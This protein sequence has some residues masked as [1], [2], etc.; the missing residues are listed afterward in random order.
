MSSTTLKLVEGGT[1]LKLGE[2]TVE[3]ARQADRARDERIAA[4]TIVDDFGTEAATALATVQTVG[5]EK[6][7]AAEVFAQEA[8]T[9]AGAFY[10]LSDAANAILRG[11]AIQTL[12]VAPGRAHPDT[13]EQTIVNPRFVGTDPDTPVVPISIS[14]TGKNLVDLSPS[15]W[16]IGQYAPTGDPTGSGSSLRTKTSIPITPGTEYVRSGLTK[17]EITIKDANDVVTRVIGQTDGIPDSFVAGPN[18][19]AVDLELFG[20]IDAR[21]AY[22]ADRKVQL[23]KGAVATTYE[24]YREDRRTYSGIE[25]YGYAGVSDTLE[26]G[27][28]TRRIVR[29]TLR[30]TA[31]AGAWHM[32]GPVNTFGNFYRMQVASAA[33]FA[34]E[35][36]RMLGGRSGAAVYAVNPASDTQARGV[37]TSLTDARIVLPK[38][39]VDGTAGADL[40]AKFTAYLNANP[41]EVF[42]DAGSWSDTERVAGGMIELPG[43][44]SIQLDATGAATH[45]IAFHAI[46]A[47]TAGGSST[48]ITTLQQNVASLTALATA[49]QTQIDNLLLDAGDSNPEVVAA[50]T[51]ETTIEDL[52]LGGRL[53]RME[54]MYPINVKDHGAKGDGVTNDT[55][56]VLYARDI[57]A[58]FGRDLYF[59]RSSG[60]YMMDRGINVP[61]TMTILGDDPIESALKKI[62]AVSVEID[63]VVSKDQTNIPVPNAATTLAGKVGAD[64]CLG[65]SDSTNTYDNTRGKITAVNANSIDIES[66]NNPDSTG[67]KRGYALATNDATKVVL[68]TSF[69][70]VY[71]DKVITPGVGVIEPMLANIGFDG[72][73][74]PGEINAY[75]CSNWHWDPVVTNGAYTFNVISKNSAAD[76]FSDQSSGLSVFQKV[77]VRA[78][79]WH[80][81]H[82]G[83][84]SD[85]VSIRDYDTE[86]GIDGLYFCQYNRKTRLDGF[87]IRNAEV[88]IRE[89][90]PTDGDVHI[91][92]GQFVACDTDI[93]IVGSKGMLFVR[94]QSIGNKKGILKADSG[95]HFDIAMQVRGALGTKLAEIT[96]CSSG[97]VHIDAPDF[98]GQIGVHILNQGAN[99]NGRCK[100]LT[101]TGQIGR[102][103]VRDG[104]NVV[105]E[106]ARGASVASVQVDSAD[107]V[108]VALS[109]SYPQGSGVDFI[110][111]AGTGGTASTGTILKAGVRGGVRAG[112]PYVDNGVG[113]FDEMAA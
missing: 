59:P 34:A 84:T 15:K 2:N 80:S 64:F 20:I 38:A 104:N 22:A 29:R 53:N 37:W 102:P 32:T 89:L 66:Y 35:I 55:E 109:H 76:G 96:R 90:D 27:K 36:N 51:S 11:D 12:D 30:G 93:Q 79:Y 24:P 98:E 10:D 81:G 106:A 57:A 60:P 113:T 31:Q 48:Q 92:N 69:P 41:V 17:P 26:D 75:P 108:V 105:V 61:R 13:G 77:R 97:R 21:P 49:L 74:Q 78:S 111:G 62:P 95:A 39:D 42:F 50:R 25:L 58:A 45:E 83:F 46:K 71:T 33:T 65:F 73:R 101:V 107:D 5:Q 86:G 94:A 44:G 112:R 40:V 8:A 85:A 3:A 87:T 68:S 43:G 82:I 67:L 88:A 4:Q 7:D 19:V 91:T 18:E 110:I 100:S 54:R 6:V 47:G 99:D 23:E 63:V 9:H 70:L 28:V 103:E 52:L 14:A 16:E 56:K 72:N 1:V